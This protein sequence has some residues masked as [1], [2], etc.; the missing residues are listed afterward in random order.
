MQLDTPESNF[1][2]I[3]NIPVLSNQKCAERFPK[4][5]G[6]YIDV[7]KHVCG[8]DSNKQKDTCLGDSGGPLNVRGNDGRWHLVG[9]TSW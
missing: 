3:A 8:V 2:R 9:L 1:L 5:K 4:E 7:N 6:Y